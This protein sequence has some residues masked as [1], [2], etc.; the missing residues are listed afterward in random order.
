MCACYSCNHC[1]KC[2][3]RAR[4]I[5]HTCP[6]CRQ[7]VPPNAAACPHCGA[8]LPPPPGTPAAPVEAGA[9]LRSELTFRFLP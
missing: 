8:P 3:E 7:K 2:V 9:P 1:G 4:A 5:A 6:A